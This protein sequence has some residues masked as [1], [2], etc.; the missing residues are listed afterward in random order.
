MRQPK[1]LFRIPFTLYW[2]GR[3]PEQFTCCKF[4]YLALFSR[5]FNGGEYF[6]KKI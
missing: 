5:E 6:Y 4:K 2:V 3:L 1:I